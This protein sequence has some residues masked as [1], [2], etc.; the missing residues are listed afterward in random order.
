MSTCYVAEDGQRD[1]VTA[2]QVNAEDGQ[3]DAVSYLQSKDSKRN[4][5]CPLMCLHPRFVNLSEDIYHS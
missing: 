2:S 1:A 4:C 5:D 3:S